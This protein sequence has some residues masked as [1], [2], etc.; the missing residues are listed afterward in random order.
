MLNYLFG[1]EK[2]SSETKRKHCHVPPGFDP[3]TPFM[4]G[5]CSATEPCDY[6]CTFPFEAFTGAGR[7][8]SGGPRGEGRK[9]ES[10]GRF[11]GLLACDCEVLTVSF[12]WPGSFLQ[13]VP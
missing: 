10:P 4:L 7:S 9:P 6:H 1:W 2:M 13:V 5:M 12:L 11:G 3:R 8:D